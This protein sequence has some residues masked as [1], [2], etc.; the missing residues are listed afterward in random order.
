MDDFNVKVWFLG[1]YD[2]DTGINVIGLGDFA[3][4]DSI[5]HF[6]PFFTS[7][8]KALAAKEALEM[9]NDEMSGIYPTIYCTTINQVE[10]ANEYE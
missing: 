1:L 3:G 6:L 4:D 9:N 8:E 2:E 7:Y 10:E 5:G